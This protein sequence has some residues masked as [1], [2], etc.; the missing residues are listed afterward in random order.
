MG[1]GSFSLLH[2]RANLVIIFALYF[3]SQ[4]YIFVNEK[5]QVEKRKITGSH[6]ALC[7]IM[8]R[9]LLACR[10]F[11]KEFFS[12]RFLPDALFLFCNAA[13]R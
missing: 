6:Q 8:A 10:Q 13:H 11:L 4:I 3:E 2:F 7:Y 9:C 1:A 12:N 5:C